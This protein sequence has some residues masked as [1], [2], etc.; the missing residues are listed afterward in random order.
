M[1][2]TTA[3]NDRKA[4]VVFDSKKHKTC[5]DEGEPRVVKRLG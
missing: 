1:S 3:N 4:I 2:P 5:R